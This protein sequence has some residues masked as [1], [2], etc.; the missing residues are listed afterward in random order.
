MFADD[1]N[2]YKKFNKDVTNFYVFEQLRK[3]Q[4]RVHKWGKHCRVE[5]DPSK[6]EFKILHHFFGE[7][8][9]FKLLGV[10]MDVKLT[11]ATEI[12]KI[13]KKARPKIT[14]MLRTRHV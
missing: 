10:M 14:A 9:D 13:M 6:E 7:G 11:M 3:C 12:D 4:E 1:L 2:V 8:A 5:F